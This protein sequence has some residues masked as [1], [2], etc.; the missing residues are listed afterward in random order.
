MMLDSPPVVLGNT[1]YTPGFVEYQRTLI[2]YNM[3]NNVKL[4]IMFYHDK[5]MEVVMIEYVKT[6]RNI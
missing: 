4:I 6:K 3:I 1:H 5:L 2:L